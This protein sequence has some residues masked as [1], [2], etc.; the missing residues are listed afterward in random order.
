MFDLFYSLLHR[1]HEVLKQ[2]QDLKTD[3]SQKEKKI[4]ELTEENGTL[5]AQVRFL[6][7]FSCVIR[8]SLIRLS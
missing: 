4:D 6:T 3:N 7:V 5:A 2:C 8:N 1:V